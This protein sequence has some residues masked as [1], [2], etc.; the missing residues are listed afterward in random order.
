MS[1]TKKEATEVLSVRMPVLLIRELRINA[2]K[3]RRTLQGQLALIIDREFR[4]PECQLLKS[5]CNCNNP[6][7]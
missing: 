4:C 7:K 5:C 3:E 6:G 1:K 2:V